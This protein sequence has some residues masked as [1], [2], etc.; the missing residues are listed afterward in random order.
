MYKTFFSLFY[1]EIGIPYLLLYLYLLKNP[2]HALICIVYLPVLSNVG[3]VE[4]D[5]H[6][7]DPIAASFGAKF[8]FASF[9]PKNRPGISMMLKRASALVVL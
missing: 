7:V 2:F 3:D 8:F 1:F 6:K 5:R 4:K 9:W